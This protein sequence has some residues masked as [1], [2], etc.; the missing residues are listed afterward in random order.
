MDIA[1]MAME[2]MGVV[3]GVTGSRDSVTRDLPSTAKAG[4]EEGLLRRL[5]MGLEYTGKA[6]TCP[7]FPESW[8]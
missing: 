5:H 8:E 1:L 7:P 4:L 6:V 3:I 2:S